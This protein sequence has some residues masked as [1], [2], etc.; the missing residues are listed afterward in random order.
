MFLQE[1]LVESLAE[2]TDG[3]SVSYCDDLLFWPTP[4]EIKKKRK[5]RFSKFGEEERKVEDM[6]RATYALQLMTEKKSFDD[7]RGGKK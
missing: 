6:T 7:K 3:K 2:N 5:T 4:Q 1:V